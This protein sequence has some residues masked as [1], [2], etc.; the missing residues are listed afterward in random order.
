[1]DPQPLTPPAVF[2]NIEEDVI[3]TVPE[4]KE[5]PPPDPPCEEEKLA[6]EFP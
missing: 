1:M 4:P 3:V 6:A 2:P 5:T